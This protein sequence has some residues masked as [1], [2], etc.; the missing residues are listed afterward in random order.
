LKPIVYH[1]EIKEN[2]NIA[3]KSILGSKLRTII[4]GLII[5]IG[6]MSLVGMLTAIEGLDKAIMAN[7]NK[8]GANSFTVR[9]KSGTGRIKGKNESENIV[10]TI[11]SFNQAVAFK[12]RMSNQAD[13]SI[14]A[15]IGMAQTIKSE[16]GQTNPNSR[17]LAIDENYITIS[18]TE[19][20]EGRNF[21]LTEMQLGTPV[22]I[23]GMDI[24]K[25]LF[26]G[27]ILDSFISYNGNRYKV[28]G[29]LEKKG[30]SMGFGGE[31]RVV[32]IPVNHAKGKYLNA[33]TNFVISASVSNIKN[34]EFVMDEA[35][36]AMR[37]IRNLKPIE[38]NNFE[39]SKSDA[40]VNDLKQNLYAI[41]FAATIISFITLLGA[42][43]GLMN[44]MLVSV[45]ERTKEI[46]TRKAL[47]ATK[48]SI[49]T[50]FLTEALV[51]CQLGGLLGIILGIT[52]GNMVGLLMNT[53]FVIPWLWIL[54]AVSIS[55]IVGI[56]A[57]IYPAR[58]ASKLDPIEA[59]RHE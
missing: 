25:A 35:I 12:N 6:I 26:K 20:I 30:S 5:A 34:I 14:S 11:I 32:Y 59:L 22:A 43:I 37:S 10:Y 16:Y 9:N 41:T 58:K 17:I 49:L 28:I 29:V 33:N 47:G 7:F 21:S 42:A 38:S 3:W 50:Q 39:I 57:G 36:L 55:F 27:P 15:A 8:M 13:V 48:R 52:I 46:G 24:K 45:T 23:V 4:T 40:L 53:P 54:V 19:I 18:G 1:L 51:I 44:I 56:T 31:D 2:L